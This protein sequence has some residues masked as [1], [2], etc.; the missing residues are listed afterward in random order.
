VNLCHELAAGNADRME[1][2]VRA[3]AP[4]LF[5]VS[6]NGA[7]RSGGWSELIRPL[8]EGNC[9]VA[10]FLK[11]LGQI[12]YTGPIGLQCYNLKGDPEENLKRSITAWRRISGSLRQAGEK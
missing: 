5:L 11:L 1:A 9:D 3:C 12:G 7:D 8:D 6:I 4:L 10:G 2:I